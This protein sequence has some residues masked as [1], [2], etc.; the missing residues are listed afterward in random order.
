MALQFELPH[1]S[2][3]VCG[4]SKRLLTGTPLIEGEDDA[5]GFPV[6]ADRVEGK[7]DNDGTDDGT[8]DTSELGEVGA[9]V[10]LEEGAIVGPG[11]V[12]F[13]RLG[14]DETG[15]SVDRI[16][17]RVCVQRHQKRFQV[18][19]TR[20]LSVATRTFGSKYKHRCLLN[21]FYCNSSSRDG[22]SSFFMTVPAFST[23]NTHWNAAQRR[24]RR[25]GR[26]SRL[27]RGRRRRNRRRRVT[28][29]GHEVHIVDEHSSNVGRLRGKK[30]L[31]AHGVVPI[32][33]RNGVP[34][35]PEVNLVGL[36][37][38]HVRELAEQLVVDI[39]E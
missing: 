24:R 11:T 15:A 12:E 3:H 17:S 16:S 37:R 9:A 38:R 35:R 19:K 32:R 1:F 10:T 29:R 22:E 33:E 6:P 39:V 8:E 20:Q 27:G 4:C 36:E 34:P 18:R 28:T 25:G 14:A 7:V 2:E 21:D 26:V 31:Q 23:T 30:L 5:E 13:A